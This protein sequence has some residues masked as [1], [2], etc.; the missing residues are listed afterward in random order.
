M[1]FLNNAITKYNANGLANRGSISSVTTGGG[2]GGSGGSGNNEGSGGPGTNIYSEWIIAISRK[3]NTLVPNWS[4][5]TIDPSTNIGY[6][7][8]GGSGYGASKF[9]PYGGGGKIGFSSSSTSGC[10]NELGV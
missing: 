4:S 8:S 5:Y 10:A 3:M 2:G 1:N 7:A 6:I 9:A